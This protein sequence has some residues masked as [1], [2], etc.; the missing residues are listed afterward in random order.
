MRFKPPSLNPKKF[1]ALFLNSA[2]KMVYAYFLSS[3]ISSD[4]D[5]R[6]LIHG[7]RYMK[8]LVDKALRILKKMPKIIKSIK[9]T[10]NNE[11]N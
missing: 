7:N 10:E 5:F 1:L 3:W 2:F 8:I 9:E 6:P 11:K 4:F